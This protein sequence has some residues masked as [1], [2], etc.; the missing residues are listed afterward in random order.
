[1]RKVR[2]LRRVSRVRSVSGGLLRVTV[3]EGER[4]EEASEGSSQREWK[5]VAFWAQPI[6]RV[7]QA[8]KIHRPRAQSGDRTGRSRS[9]VVDPRAQSG[10]RTGGSRGQLGERERWSP[11]G[12]LKSSRKVRFLKAI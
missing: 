11:A 4:L 2:K 6:E 12:V 10:D 3:L 9:H 8:T 5:S 1:V 7:S